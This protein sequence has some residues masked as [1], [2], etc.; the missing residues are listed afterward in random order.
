MPEERNRFSARHKSTRDYAAELGSGAGEHCADKASSGGFDYLAAE[1]EAQDESRPEPA[2]QMPGGK[3]AASAVGTHS[4]MFSGAYAAARAKSKAGEGYSNTYYRDK[5]A[6]AQAD[7]EY[8]ADQRAALESGAIASEAA[9]VDYSIDPESDW[10]NDEADIVDDI[11]ASGD[12]EADDFEAPFGAMSGKDK[13]KLLAKSYAKGYAKGKAKSAAKAT[14]AGALGEMQ[15]D[16]ADED[17]VKNAPRE[18]RGAYRAGKTAYSFVRSPAGRAA[19]RTASAPRTAAEAARNFVAG[20]AAKVKKAFAAA[21]AAPK[22]PLVWIAAFAAA[23]FIMFPALFLVT[24]AGGDGQDDAS[25]DG[26]TANEAA[27]AQWLLD[28]GFTKEAAAGILGN[29]AN[30]GGFDPAGWEVNNDGVGYYPYERAFGMFQYTS[31]SPGTGLYHKFKSWC[32][33]N[34]KDPFQHASSLEFTFTSRTG[35]F[36]ESL[37]MMGLATNGYYSNCP[38]YE[39]VDGPA[40]SASELKDADS[41]TRAAYSWMACY[42]RCANGGRAHLDRRLDSAEQY[43]RILCGEGSGGGIASVGDLMW[44][45][46]EGRWGTYAGHFGLD[47]QAAYGTPIYAPADG[48]VIWGGRSWE[49]TYGNIVRI[50]HD[51]LGLQTACAHMSATSVKSGER[52]TKGQIIGYCGSTGNSSGPHIHFELYEKNDP[53][54]GGY[55]IMDDMDKWALY[56]DRAALQGNRV[57]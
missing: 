1:N 46:S 18:V 34:G 45:S 27:V 22:N 43:Y 32:S 38:G 50:Y 41:V 7:A 52:V 17:M 15:G 5:E 57:W 12:A 10:A 37:W 28:E 51:G 16:S 26:F 42:E 23:V 9:G 33:E 39:R 11:D 55:P 8:A 31:T 29:I 54:I 36:Y 6:E 2:V 53:M 20:G 48:L 47:I 49:T 19:A 35:G 21:A 56:F 44:P 25:L 4:A 40:Y 3:A 14:V 13:T 24:C 30:E